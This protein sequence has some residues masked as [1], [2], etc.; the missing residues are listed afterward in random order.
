MLIGRQIEGVRTGL[1]RKILELSAVKSNAVKLPLSRVFFI[2]S[3]VNP[4]PPFVEPQR[5]SGLKEG[6]RRVETPLTA[7]ELLE[8]FSIS[9]V[10]VGVKPTVP[11]G[12]PKKALTLLQKQRRLDRI[13]PVRVLLDQQLTV[14]SRSRVPEVDRYFVLC[15]VQSQKRDFFRV[16]C[17]RKFWRNILHLRI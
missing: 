15:P 14:I 3:K 13:N 16:G 11:F 12:E 2:G 17:P 4:P 10:K 7:G 9:P 5:G 8:K 1:F 6:G